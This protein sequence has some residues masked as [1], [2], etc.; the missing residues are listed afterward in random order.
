MDETTRSRL[1]K[2]R[3]ECGCQ[4]GAVALLISVGAYVIHAVRLDPVT[5]SHREQVIIGIF[6]GLAGAL[7]G[8][9]LGILWARH[10]YRQL[11]STQGRSAM[12]PTGAA[13]RVVR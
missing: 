8:K 6:V 13:G 12:P 10:Q 4:A 11:L 9:I 3:S 7:I 1:A 2:L 5:S